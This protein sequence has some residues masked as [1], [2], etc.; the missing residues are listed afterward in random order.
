MKEFGHLYGLCFQL[1]DDVLGVTGDRSLTG[2]PVGNDV[3]EGKKTLVMRYVLDNAPESDRR[4]LLSIFGNRS[5]PAEEI[6]YALSVVS[7]SKA[8]DMIRAEAKSLSDKAIDIL[9][10]FQRSHPRDMLINL[11]SE[12]S[13]RSK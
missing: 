3:R 2:K 13:T 9:E 1:I 7:K 5:A 10:G 12:A 4:K 11:A 6:Q 8:P